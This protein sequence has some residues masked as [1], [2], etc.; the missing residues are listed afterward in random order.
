[1]RTAVLAMVALALAAPATAQE[2]KAAVA[3]GQIGEQSDGY[4]GV[5]GANAGLAATVSSINIQRK[6]AYS[7]AAA[8]QGATVEAIGIAAGCNQIKRL[9]AGAK[10]RTGGTWHTVGDGALRLDPRCP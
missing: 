1:M 9:P 3:A 4:L 2:W 7:D 10:Y 5:V 8:A 6:K